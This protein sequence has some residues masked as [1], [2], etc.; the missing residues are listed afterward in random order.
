V[1]VFF[2]LCSP[3]YPLCPSPPPFHWCLLSTLGRTFFTL[4]FSDF[5][6]KKRKDKEK[7]MTFFPVWCKSSYIGSFLVV[8]PCMYVLYTQLVYLL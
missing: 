3:S 1:K 2:P 4:P 6:E 7:N 8:F 5:A